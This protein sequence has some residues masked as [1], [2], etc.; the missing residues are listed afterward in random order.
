VLSLILGTDEAGAS[1]AFAS[2]LFSIGYLN[3]G[4]K[5]CSNTMPYFY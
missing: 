4:K 3:I 1:E 5:I 2:L